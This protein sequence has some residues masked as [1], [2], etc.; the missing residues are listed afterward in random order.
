MNYPE[1]LKNRLVFKKSKSFEAEVKLKEVL[2]PEPHTCGD[3]NEH[4]ITGYAQD[5][6]YCQGNLWTK[7]HLKTHCKNCDR[8]LNP[9]TGKFDLE[10]KEYATVYKNYYHIEKKS[11]KN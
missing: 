2:P 6:R 10:R 11:H 3:C 9:L 1:W 7:G 5:L 4:T 8:W